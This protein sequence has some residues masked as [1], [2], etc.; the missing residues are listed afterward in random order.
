MH[1]AMAHIKYLYVVPE[2]PQKVF[3]AVE[4]GCIVRSLDGGGHW[5]TLSRAC[6]A[7]DSHAV[8][9]VPGQPYVV[10][11]TT[12]A[13]V[14]RSEN[15]AERCIKSDEGRDAGFHVE[16]SADRREL[17]CVLQTHIPLGEHLIV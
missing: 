6:V 9:T 15:L 4:E 13:G 1:L 7:F 5:E 16:R 11:A 3:G 10:I 14:Y 8:T 17:F 12:G 2:D